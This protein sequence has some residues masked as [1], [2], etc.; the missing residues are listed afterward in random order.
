MGLKPDVNH[1]RLLQLFAVLA[2]VCM[3]GAS[4]ATAGAA[5]YA[6]TPDVSNLLVPGAGSIFVVPALSQ[7]TRPVP[8]VVRLATAPFPLAYGV[9]AQRLAG[10]VSPPPGR[11]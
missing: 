5:Q 3:I 10:H 9:T 8:V 7:T 11:D 2:L 4:P 1:D 6:Q